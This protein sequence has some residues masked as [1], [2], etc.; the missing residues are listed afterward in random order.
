[1]ADGNRTELTRRALSC[2]GGIIPA[3]RKKTHTYKSTC[4]SGCKVTEGNRALT[5]IPLVNDRESKR[6]N[7]PCEGVRTGGPQIARIF[8]K[9][10][11]C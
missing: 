2:M 1:V 3:V 7:G 9:G 10:N 6:M 11:V 8:V 4:S 5:G